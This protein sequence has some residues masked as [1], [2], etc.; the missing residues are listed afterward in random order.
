M[1]IFRK[2]IDS[3][4]AL[5]PLL[6]PELVSTERLEGIDEFE[7]YA[8]LTYSLA[9]PLGIT[10]MMDD[11]EDEMGLN[12]LYY[13]RPFSEKRGEGFQ[14]CAYATP[15]GG[16]MYKFNAQTR[17]DGLVHTLYVYIFTSLEIMLE[18][19]KDDLLAH[20]GTGVF[21]SKMSYPRLIADFM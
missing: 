16:Q 17:K 1:D 12:I 19:L 13:I 18:C 10:R 21:K 14:C 2:E 3:F 20:E 15:T 11:M 6:L 8:M 7:D 9:K 4:H 5:A